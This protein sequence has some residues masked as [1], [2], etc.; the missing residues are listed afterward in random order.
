VHHE[1]QLGQVELV[2][3]TRDRLDMAVVRVP[4]DLRGLVRAT[5]PDQIRSD[6]S[7]RQL[8]DDVPPEKRRGRLAVEQQDRRAVA[9]VDVVQAMAVDLE[10]VGGEA[11]DRRILR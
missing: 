3:E 10:P 9:L 11:L 5:E 7:S 6:L 4:A 1:G 8:R 2:N